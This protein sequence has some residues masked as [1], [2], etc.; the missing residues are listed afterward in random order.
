MAFRR[1]GGGSTIDTAGW[2]ASNFVVK[3][4]DGGAVAT[5][6]ILRGGG[7]GAGAG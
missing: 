3:D 6:S 2:T 1:L 4:L 7:G 5:W